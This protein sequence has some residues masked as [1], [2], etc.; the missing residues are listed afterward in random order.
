MNSKNSSP[1]NDLSNAENNIALGISDFRY[2]DLYDTSRLQTLT[3]CFLTEL[4][5]SDDV[6]AQEFAKYRVIQGEGLAQKDE[7]N[8]L[9]KVAPYLSQFV[10]KLFHVTNELNAHLAQA[11]NEAVISDYK[12]LFIQRRVKKLSTEA[13][14]AAVAEFSALDEQ[15]KN[16]FAQQNLTEVDEELA[17]AKFWQANKENAE[18]L[19]T[20]EQW[21]AALPEVAP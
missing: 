6:L 17:A 8:L 11:E 7:S 1:A 4:E 19:T 9:V 12:K 21:A 13:V 5:K 3:E 2:A 10:A 20:L 14:A 16:F 15:V 18:S